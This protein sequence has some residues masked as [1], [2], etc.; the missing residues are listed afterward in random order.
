MVNRFR[1]DIQ[2]RGARQQ[3]LAK[4]ESCCAVRCK[5]MPEIKHTTDKERVSRVYKIDVQSAPA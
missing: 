4:A 2:G 1:G 5:I 3:N